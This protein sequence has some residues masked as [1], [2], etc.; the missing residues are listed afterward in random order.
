MIKNKKKYTKQAQIE[1]SILN[2]IRK[3]DPKGYS[4]I[5][6]IHGSFIFRKHQVLY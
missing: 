6:E 1:I 5:V 2:N 3:L 4:G